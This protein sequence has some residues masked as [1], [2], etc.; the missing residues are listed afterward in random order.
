MTFEKTRRKPI[1]LDEDFEQWLDAL[2]N[3]MNQ[4]LPVGR[5]L[6][7]REVSKLVPRM[8]VPMKKVEIS[9]NV[10]QGKRRDVGK[11]GFF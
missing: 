11:V 5:K 2:T 4:N 3:H 10:V 9:I 1:W 6:S 7:R 8:M